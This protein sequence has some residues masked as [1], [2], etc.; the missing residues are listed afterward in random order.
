MTELSSTLLSDYSKLS[1]DDIVR[2]EMPADIAEKCLKFCQTFVGGSWNNA[3]S[4][5]EITIKRISGGLANL[6]VHV[7]LNESVAKE[8]NFV[9][10]KEPSDVAIKFYSEKHLNFNST[11]SERFNELNI[12]TITSQNGISP[13]IYGIAS[14]GFVQSFYQHEQFR[15]KHQQD[16]KLLQKLAKQ[17]ARFHYLQVPINKTTNLYI[18]QISK[19]IESA[20]INCPE[21]DLINELPLKTLKSHDLQTEFTYLMNVVEKLNSPIVFAHNDFRSSNILVTDSSEVLLVDFE[22]NSYGPR[23]FDLATFFTEWGREQ[24]F[25]STGLVLPD[26]DVLSI[27]LKLYIHEVDQIVPGYSKDEKNS[28]QAHV[29][30]TKI[31][32][33]VNLLFYTAFMLQMMESLVPSVPFDGHKKMLTVE[34]TYQLYMKIKEELLSDGTLSN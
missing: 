28:L 7:H 23:C 30:E 19:M 34:L 15:A 10:C 33:L 29:K 32:F 1:E 27:F 18:K 22:T 5:S 21:I 20:K 6:M 11:D 16:G 24:L 12:L 4:S 9:Y 14:D 26:D 17:I 13:T 31:M 3:K 8:T 2:C 25:A